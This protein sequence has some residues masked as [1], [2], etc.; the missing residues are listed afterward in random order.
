MK[1]MGTADFLIFLFAAFVDLGVFFLL[2]SM[3]RRDLVNERVIRSLDTALR[4]QRIQ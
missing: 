4:Y 2:R 3:R 1:V